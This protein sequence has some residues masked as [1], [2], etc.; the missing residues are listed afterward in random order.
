MNSNCLLSEKTFIS[1]SFF[2]D[3]SLLDE[4]IDTLDQRRFLMSL[5]KEWDDRDW[6]LI[7]ILSRGQELGFLVVND[8]VERLRPT[9][10]KVRSL[11]LR[12]KLAGSRVQDVYGLRSQRVLPRRLVTGLEQWKCCDVP[13]MTGEWAAPDPPRESYFV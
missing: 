4:Q 6:L 5:G 12:H 9:E 10:D 3:H 11:E 8:P 7:P 2:C 1:N 13:A